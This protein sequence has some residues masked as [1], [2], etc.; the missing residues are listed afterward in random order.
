[1]GI[2]YPVASESSVDIVYSVASDSLHGLR[3]W[4]G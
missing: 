2:V 4:R 3:V 1:M